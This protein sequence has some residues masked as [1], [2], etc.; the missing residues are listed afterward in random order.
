MRG[1]LPPLEGGAIGDKC[2]V[3]GKIRLRARGRAPMEG[4]LFQV[5]ANRRATGVAA[6]VPSLIRDIRQENDGTIGP[7]SILL[8]KYQ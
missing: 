7:S 5:P 1:S 3:V 8:I 4:V 2:I 6:S